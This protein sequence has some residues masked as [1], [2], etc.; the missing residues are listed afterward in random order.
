MSGWNPAR[1]ITTAAVLAL[2]GGAGYFGYR[3]LRADLAASVYRARLAELADNY[4]S[5]RATYNEA[6]RKTAVTELLVHEGSL[7]VRVRT[8]DGILKTIET[9]FDPRREIYVDYVVL[10]GRLWIRRVFDDATRP[11]DAVVIDPALAS[12][13]WNEKGAAHGKAVYR[14]LTDGRWVI[15]VTGDGSLGLARAG[16]VDDPPASE[17]MHAPGV[18]DYEEITAAARA[19]ADAIGVGEVLE[20]LV[21][22]D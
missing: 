7:C 3:M 10:D 11:A 2:A 22:G 15:T 12:I 19:E 8:S 21:G 5:L 17:L 20:W 18:K 13:T 9:P 4:E 6:I 1:W 16:D 14:S